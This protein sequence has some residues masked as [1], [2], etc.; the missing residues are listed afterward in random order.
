[1][2]TG[3]F[4]PDGFGLTGF[5]GEDAFVVLLVQ[6]NDAGGAEVVLRGAAGGG[7]QA[8]Q[9][10]RGAEDGDRAG[11]HA[12][13]ITDFVEQAV[14][15]VFYQF[16]YAADTGGNGGNAA[17]HG[18]ECGPP[19]GFHLRGH[20][21]E[22]GEGEELVHVLLLADEVDAIA[23]AKPHSEELGCRALGPVA[24]HKQACRKCARDAGERLDDV[25]DAPDGAEVR[26]VYE[27]ALA[28]PGKAW[29]LFGNELGIANVEVAVDEV[30][31]HF[32]L[33]RDAEIFAGAFAE[34]RGDRSDAV[35]LVDA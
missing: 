28:R 18:F 29:A 9:Q 3:N 24:D 23:D 33:A 15:A 6:R 27:E 19:E 32:D 31:D 1:M 35:G 14:D 8:L 34:V 2:L 13:D 20:E 11:G 30:A 22:V 4:G 21:H 25:E 5:L 7:G 10:R 26:E 16:R 12:V 17:G